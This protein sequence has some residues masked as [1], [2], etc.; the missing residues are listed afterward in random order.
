MLLFDDHKQVVFTVAFSPDG[1]TLASAS[2]DKTVRVWELASERQRVLRGHQ[3]SVNRVAWRGDKHLVTTS[4]DGTLRVWDVPV[5]DPPPAH[6]L[7]AQLARAT[8]ARI[9]I[10][11][12]TTTEAGRRGI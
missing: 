10:D 12:P 7:S 11:R 1:T 5:L 8:S 9:E 6:E 4:R 3:L 2:Y